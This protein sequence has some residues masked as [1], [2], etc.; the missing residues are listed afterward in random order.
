MITFMV[1]FYM[2][3]L[4]EIL[5]IVALKF[6]S[7]MVGKN[8]LLYFSNSRIYSDLLK[9]KKEIRKK[10]CSYFVKLFIMW[11]RRSHG[12]S[13]RLNTKSWMPP[14][15]RQTRK[16]A[17]KLHWGRESQHTFWWVI[18]IRDKLMLIPESKISWLSHWKGL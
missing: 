16:R 13:S 9:L 17:W 15:G 18:W 5:L 14:K 10:Q 2:D 3:R 12:R 7:M 6:K 11:F 1:N 4:S 8:S